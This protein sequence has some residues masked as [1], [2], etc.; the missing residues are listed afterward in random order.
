MAELC[1]AL[2]IAGLTAYAV[3]GGADLGAGLWDLTAGGAE[4]GGRVRGL[5]QRSMSPVWEA[6][7]VW[8]PFLL[9]VLWTAFPV[10]F[11]SIMSTLYVPLFG[12]ALGII[13]RGA[14]FAVR[15]QAAT[16]VE[17]RALGALFA[18]SSLL[19]PFCLGAALGGIASGRV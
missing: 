13:L 11:G 19:V 9:V 15:G 8:M 12:A 7:H 4:R 1:L 6:N 5:V 14:A 10:F 16:L 2:A 3:L 18:S 17:A